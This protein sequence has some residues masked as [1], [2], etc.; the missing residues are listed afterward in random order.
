MI[1]PALVSA[2]A[3]HDFVAAAKFSLVAPGFSIRGYAWTPRSALALTAAIED[4]ELEAACLD[5][6]ESLSKHSTAT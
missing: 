4:L 2:S 6:I 3:A 1:R 5:A